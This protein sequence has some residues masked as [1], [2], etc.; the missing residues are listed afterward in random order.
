[1][2][3][4]TPHLWRNAGPTELRFVDRFTPALDIEGFFARLCAIDAAGRANRAGIAKNPFELAVFF[5][6][7]RDEIMFPT[8]GQ[9]RVIGSILHV[10]AVVGRRMGFGQGAART[11]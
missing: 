2:T 8:E 3:P 1:M 11:H 7:Y 6:D 4:N 9:Q 5:D 10:M